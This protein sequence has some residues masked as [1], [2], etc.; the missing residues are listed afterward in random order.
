MKAKL[1][2]LRNI[3]FVTFPLSKF[4]FG[5]CTKE[6][7]TRH[8]WSTSNYVLFEYHFK[9]LYQF[10]I[11]THKLPHTLQIKITSI[12]I[13]ENPTANITFSERLKY[14]PL[15]SKNS[16]R[17]ITF[18]TFIQHSI[19]TSSQSNESRKRNKRHPN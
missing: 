16:T 2:L 8:I 18:S 10:S 6:E 13:Y 1:F 3:F 9:L 12:A 17:M 11:I 7:I 15:R 5:S 4:F 19:G 14:F